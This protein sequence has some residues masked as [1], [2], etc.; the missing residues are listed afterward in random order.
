MTNN[1][2]DENNQTEEEKIK[3]YH[4][5]FYRKLVAEYNSNKKL[6]TEY[7]SFKSAVSALISTLETL[8]SNIEMTHQ[9]VLSAISFSGFEASISAIGDY[10]NQVSNSIA[11]LDGVI[12]E[13]NNEIRKLEERNAE[14]RVKI[15]I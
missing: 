9:A 1:K 8:K 7:D 15:H 4:E 13:I 11:S 12:S 14:I 3:W 5:L 6:I 10:A 2:N